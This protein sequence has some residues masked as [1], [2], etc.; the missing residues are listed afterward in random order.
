MLT[1]ITLYLPKLVFE[2]ATSTGVQGDIAID[3]IQVIPGSCPQPGSCDFEHGFCGFSNGH[4]R[5]NFDWLRT[6][7]GTSSP[8]TGPVVDH[9]TNSDQGL[10]KQKGVKFIITEKDL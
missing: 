5:D 2:G 10:L 9:T 3:D 6:T 8:A 4:G 7:G 1:T